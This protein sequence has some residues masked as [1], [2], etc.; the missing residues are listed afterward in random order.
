MRSD[1]DAFDQGKSRF[2]KNADFFTTNR[3]Q[4][5]VDYVQVQEIA[6]LILL[7]QN[8]C[9][10]VDGPLWQGELSPFEELGYFL[11]MT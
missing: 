9:A 4:V 3:G 8:L 10:I 1:I 5:A 7:K 6:Q 2:H 11:A